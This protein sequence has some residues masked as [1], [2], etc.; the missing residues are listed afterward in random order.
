MRKNILI[1]GVAGMIGSHLLELK[2]KKNTVYG[3]DNF[4]NKK[5]NLI[6]KFYSDKNFH[7]KKLDVSE[8]LNINKKTKFDEIWLLAANSDI[9][10]GI[11]NHQVDFKNTFLTN[12]NFLNQIKKNLYKN[13][14]KIIFTSSSAI[15]G[16]VKKKI[17]SNHG[18]FK[19][20]SNYGAMKAASESF[21][22]YFASNHNVKYYIFRLPNVI[23][24]NFTHGIIKDFINKIKL[25]KKKFNVLGNGLQKKP[26]VHANDLISIME[27]IVKKKKNLKIIFIIYLL[28]I[29]VLMLNILQKL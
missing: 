4:L 22:S 20:I 25:K 18:P 10:K 23:S 8:K 15:Y 11:K 7:F 9:Q 28:L 21:I 12:Y 6:N 27:K 3:F 5:K 24:E 29:M 26:F 19:P 13:R 14:T 16:E 1:T 2:I 17:P